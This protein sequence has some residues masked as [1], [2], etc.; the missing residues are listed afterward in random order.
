[1]KESV[2]CKRLQPGDLSPFEITQLGWHDGLTAGM[3]RC[4]NCGSTYH[5]K[6]VAWNVANEPEHEVRV[7]GFRLVTNDTYNDVVRVVGPPGQRFEAVPLLLALRD[8]LATNFECTLYVAAADLTKVI[9]G[10]KHVDFAFW[11]SIL[12]V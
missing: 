3:A 12:R 6:L 11:S 8:S 5:F 2:C 4:R 10:A 7:Y 1:V 9:A